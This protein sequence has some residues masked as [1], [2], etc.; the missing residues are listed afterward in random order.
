MS[1]GYQC[2]RGGFFED[3][4]SPQCLGQTY[5]AEEAVISCGAHRFT[6]PLVARLGTPLTKQSFQHASRTTVFLSCCS[7]WTGFIF[8][9]CQVDSFMIILPARTGAPSLFSVI[10]S[11][12]LPDHVLVRGHFLPPS[13]PRAAAC[14]PAS[15]CRAEVFWPPTCR[16]PRRRLRSSTST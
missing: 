2:I 15:R 16:A 14:F 13:T 3:V 7:V 8:F 9:W 5:G 11:V 10:R 6:P 4:C 1:F 12:F